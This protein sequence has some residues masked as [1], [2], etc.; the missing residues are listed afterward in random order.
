MALLKTNNPLLTYASKPNIVYPKAGS[1][2]GDPVQAANLAAVRL[3]EL[4]PDFPSAAIAASSTIPPAA[5][6]SGNTR[7]TTEP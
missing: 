2:G 6:S 3:S 4:A 1:V 5:T 7:L